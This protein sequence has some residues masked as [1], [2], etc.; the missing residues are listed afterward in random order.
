MFTTERNLVLYA[1]AFSQRYT[2]EGE[3]LVGP[4]QHRPMLPG[5]SRGVNGQVLPVFGRL[6]VST[7]CS[8]GSTTGKTTGCA[9]PKE[10][11]QPHASV[12]F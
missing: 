5:R 1:P 6:T 3:L 4:T 7:K 9:S 8:R 10:A 12:V 2:G 11:G